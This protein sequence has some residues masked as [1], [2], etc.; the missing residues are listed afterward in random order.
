MPGFAPGWLAVG[1]LIALASAIT[2][3]QTTPPG[4]SGTPTLYVVSVSQASE[5]LQPQSAFSGSVPAGTATS[6]V[7]PLSLKDAIDR[8]LKQ[9]LGLLLAGERIPSARGQ[10][11]KGLSELLP[12]LTTSTKES[13]QQIN[14]ET[15]GINLS[16]LRKIAVNLSSIVGP[17]GVFDTRAYLTQS[18]FNWKSIQQTRSDSQQIRADQYSYKDARELVVLVVASAYLQTIADSA[19]LETA[20]AQQDT[21]EALYRQADDQLNVGTT[22]AI[23]VLRAKVEVQ[24]RQQQVISA[25]NELA[26]QKIILG[27][28]VGLPTGQRFRLT[29]TATYAPPPKFSFDEALSRAYASRA[30]YQSALAQL[31][32]AELARKAATAGYYPSVSTSVDY[33]DIGLNPGDSHGTLAATAALNIPIFQGGKVHGEVMQAEASLRQHRELLDN[34]RGQIEQDVRN[35]FLDMQSAA[36]QVEVARSSV[37]LANQ[38]LLQARDRFGAGVTDNIE[39][40][41]AQQSVASADE[42]LISSLYSYNVSKVELGRAI[43]NAEVGVQEYLKGR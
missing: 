13:A 40:V 23:D 33:G 28:V 10:W 25:R 29:N 9:N 24:T 14:L 1:S 35:A 26:K 8:G 22:A 38:T 15:V 34:L 6:G 27:R 32:A 11:W 12:N 16:A 37:N 21:A 36:D 20:V 2:W 19:R 41:Q 18:V 42:S 7:L 30:D 5:A 39:V 31:R 43:G 3:G 17:F 4:S